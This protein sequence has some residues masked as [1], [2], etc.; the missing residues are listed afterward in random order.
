[1]NP[2]NLLK[3]MVLGTALTITAVGC[4]MGPQNAQRI[5]G[6][7]IPITDM[8][9]DRGNRMRLAQPHIDTGI[10]P[11]RPPEYYTVDP[12]MPLMAQTIYF[13]FDK[14]AVKKADQSKLENVASYLK[15]RPEVKVRVEGNCDERG[16]EE[17]NRSLG[18]RRA[19]AAREYLVRLGIDPNRIITI[20]Y[21]EDKP[22]DPEH[23]EAAWSKNRRDDFQVLL[24]PKP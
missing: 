8:D 7:P 24:P 6:H 5:P 3:L 19:L 21:G 17:Y 4:H 11:V 10:P 23:S 12:T 14:S 13:D 22:V 2:K 16:T 18:E 9:P 20:S 1:M 15:G